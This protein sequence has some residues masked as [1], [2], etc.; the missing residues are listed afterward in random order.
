MPASEQQKTDIARAFIDKSH[1]AKARTARCAH[2]DL[3]LAAG[4]AYDFVESIAV[5]YNL[6]LPQP[7]RGTATNEQKAELLSA[8]I[9]EYV[10]AQ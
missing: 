9:A 4:A 3:R 10:Q 8:A 5:A 1:I 2:E 6:A 7:F